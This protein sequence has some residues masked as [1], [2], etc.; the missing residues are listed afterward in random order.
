MVPPRVVLDTNVVLSA[1]LFRA[2]LLAPIRTAIADRRCVPL[3]S[4][5]TANELIRVLKYPKFHLSAAEQQE[6]LADVLPFSEVVR[7]P[8]RLP[9]IPACRDP[10][11]LPFLKLAVAGKAHFL[12]SGDQDLLTITGKWPFRVVSPADFL[13][14]PGMM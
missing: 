7:I 13:K 8:A 10:G 12:V 14:I 9:K 3:V 11:D 6:L 4:V 2:G 5:E 1:L